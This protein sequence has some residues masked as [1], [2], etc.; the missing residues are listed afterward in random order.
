MAVATMLMWCMGYPRT[1]GNPRPTVAA[2]L[3]HDVDAD[4]GGGRADQVVADQAGRVIEEGAGQGQR[5]HRVGLQGEA[6][7]RTSSRVCAGAWGLGCSA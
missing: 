1:W 4:G 7:L 6:A 2:H 5:V 3:R